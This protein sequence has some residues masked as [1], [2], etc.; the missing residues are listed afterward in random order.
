MITPTN[1]DEVGTDELHASM[2]EAIRE[3]PEEHPVRAL[4]ERLDEIL[5]AGGPECLPAPWDE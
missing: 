2:A 3:L 1:L 4:W 5:T